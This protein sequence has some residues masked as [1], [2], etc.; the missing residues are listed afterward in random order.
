MSLLCL[1][2]PKHSPSPSEKQIFSMGC[3]VLC[4]WHSDNFSSFPSTSQQLLHFC[5]SLNMLLCYQLKS[6]TH[7][8]P[9]LRMFFLQISWCLH[10]ISFT[11]SS[12]FQMSLSQWGLPWT[13]YSKLKSTSNPRLLSLFYSFP[14]HLP[15]SHL[16]LYNSLLSFVCWLLFSSS[17]N[18]SS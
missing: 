18:V 17:L 10:L 16:L 8:C 3:K 4:I 12:A 14:Y 6:F 11:S 5:C 2:P 9:L 1:Q 13:S 15:S 7:V